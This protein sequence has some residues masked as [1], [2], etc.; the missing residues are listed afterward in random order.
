MNRRKGRP[1]LLDDEFLIK[2]KDM[3]TGVCMAGVVISRKT[4]TAIGTGAIKANCPSKLK[5]FGGHIALT[6]VWAR[7]VLKS[8]ERS[9]RK[10]TTSKIGSSKQFLLKEK[11]TFQ[12]HIALIIEEHDIP[13]DLILN[14]DPKTRPYVSPGKYTF[15]PK[16]A[17]TMPFK[18][19]DDKRQIT[20]TFTIYQTTNPTH[21][22]RENA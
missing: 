1:N 10:G 9:E 21:L 19:I 14:L 16:G 20:A 15:N 3:V 22:R 17:K 12:R 4:V 5:D 2:V 18:S 11:L 7:G 8:M 6:E 13:K